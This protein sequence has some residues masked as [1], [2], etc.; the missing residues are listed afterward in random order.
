MALVYVYNIVK[1]KYNYDYKNP[2]GTMENL[3]KIIK[4]LSDASRLKIVALLRKKALSDPL[5]LPKML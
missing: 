1:S 4:A 3:I 2:G 5:R